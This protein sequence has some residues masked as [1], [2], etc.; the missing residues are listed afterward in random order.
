[1]NRTW[2]RTA[3]ILGF[4]AG[5]LLTVALSLGCGSSKSGTGGVS[6]YYGNYHISTWMADHPAQAVLGVDA[7]TKC[8]EIS[9][10]KVGSGIPTCMTAGCHHQSTPGWADPGI[11][12]SRAKLATVAGGGLVSCQICHAKDFTGGASANACVTCHGVKAPHPV[13]PWRGSGGS[14]FTHTTADPSNAAVCAQCHFT[15]SPNNPAGHPFTPAAAGTQPGCFNDTLC[16]GA[17][18][19]PHAV[20]FLSG[21]TDAQG[22]GHLTASAAT[23]AA[24]CATCHAVTGTS[25]IASAPLCS[26]CHTL[27][28]PAVSATGSG[29]CLSCHVG[30]AGLPVGPTGTAFPNIKGAH[31]KHMALP[32]LVHC[33][34]CHT[35]AGT[36][37]L[38]HYNNANARPPRVPTGPAT[39]AFDQTFKAKT[40]G[41]TAFSPTAATCS[42]ISCHGGLSA[43][44]WLAG[45]INVNTQC[46]ACH[47]VATSSGTITQFNDAFGRHASGT[48]NATVAANAIACTTCH[49]MS[50]GSPAALA[51]FK[52]LN[53]TAVDG[54]A[55]GNPADQLPSGTIQ[56]D[57]AI[58][59]GAGTYTTTV[60]GTPAIK[61][62]NGGCALT[63]HTHIHTTTVDMWT[64][65]GAPHIVP[66]YGGT[67]D[68]AGNQ[69]FTV[70]A[71]QFTADCG[72][73]HVH[74]GTPPAGSTAPNCN[75]CHKLADPSVVATGAGTCQSC[76]T[77]ATIKTAGPTG[78]TFP[79][80]T[81]AHPKHMGLL[82]TLNCA[83]CHNGVGTGSTSHYDNAN[84]RVTSPVG[85]GVV[86][87]DPL[88]KAKTGGNATFTPAAQTCGAVSCHGGRTT[89]S[90]QVAGSINSATQCSACHAINAATG[91]SQY[92]DAVGRHGWGT[93]NAAAALDCTICHNMTNGSPGA[94]NH[95]KYLNTPDVSGAATGLPADQM[96]SGTINFKTNNA[97]YPITGLG[98][99][100]YLISAPTYVEGDGGCALTCHSQVHVPS[101]NHWAAAQGA[102][103][104]PVPFYDTGL[105]TQGNHHQTVTLAQFNGECISCHDVTGVTTKTGPTCI[106]CHT[107]DPTAP[108][109]GAGTCLS[110][111]VGTSGLPNGPEGTAFP[112]IQ[113]AHPK[114][115]SLLT[116]TRTSPALPAPMTGTYSDCRAC[117]NTYLPGDSTH[118]HY[119]NAEKR[120]HT[121][122]A[123]GAVAVAA[124]FNAQSGA[125]TNNGNATALTCSNVSCHGAQT[126]PGW[127]TGTL[128]VNTNSYCRAC[129]TPRATATQYNDATGTHT[130]N[131]TH[132]NSDCRI[133]HDMNNGTQGALNHWKYLDTTAVIASP[134]QLSSQT[135]SFLGSPGI[136]NTYTDPGSYAPLAPIGNGNCTVNCHYPTAQQKDH[137]PERWTP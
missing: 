50:N 81:G 86:A 116:F 77:G 82:T 21:Q 91:T 5:A 129:H 7:C 80:L 127:Q 18:S 123:P 53:T 26:T 9:I 13:K 38:T 68:T 42:N 114:H 48:H 27:G 28:N 70:T 75:V 4:A 128:A 88:F 15:G 3:R 102:A 122:V 40:G 37:S 62:G 87:I 35:G 97:T 100:P 72:S 92:N 99:P 137:A 60:T 20:P 71:A 104:H 36:T 136:N 118:T 126:T 133:C 67:P 98:T 78:T 83:T 107:N 90:W 54:V 1:M 94:T 19:A 135:I 31:A 32:T 132:Q 24:D 46:S 34:T 131:G 117:H 106:T 115:L 65:G 130:L 30:A 74:T 64:T 85:P 45:A 17:N 119:D 89:P 134:D 84:A 96:A 47:G 51:H 110:C 66:F 14:I 11:H 41:A 22:N 109:T 59:S 10:I 43:P 2:K 33:D 6:Q 113:G 55:T 49:N 29:T 56:F 57:T 103:A 25:P 93:H 23:F 63:C 112:S 12:G 95:F 108:A 16:H 8:H 105:S 120:R 61:E 121:P 125:A 79:N 101:A 58:V 73:C 44:S 39:V 52:Y 76:H 111:H 69:H 124:S